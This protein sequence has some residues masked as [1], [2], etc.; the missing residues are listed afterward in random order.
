MMIPDN[1]IYLPPEGPPILCLHIICLSVYFS[2]YNEAKSFAQGIV[3]LNVSE[4]S[5][6][7]FTD[8]KYEVRIIEGT[9]NSP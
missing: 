4:F 3:T 6:H 8:R 1:K 7:V 2:E 9:T 5:Q